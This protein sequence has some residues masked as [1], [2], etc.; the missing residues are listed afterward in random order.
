MKC[1]HC[2]KKFW[3]AP[4]NNLFCTELCSQGI[5]PDDVLFQKERKNE[6]N[7]AICEK[8]FIMKYDYQITC[9]DPCDKILDSLT[10]KKFFP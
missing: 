5:D 7:C 1:A 3:T 8:K 10:K 9:S 4:I 2:S 6:F